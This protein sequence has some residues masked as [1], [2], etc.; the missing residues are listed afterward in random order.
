VKTDTQAK[1]IPKID[2]VDWT[3]SGNALQ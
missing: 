2:D 3:A 1:K